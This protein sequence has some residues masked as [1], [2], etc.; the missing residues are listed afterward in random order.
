MR[1]QIY[2]FKS[3]KVKLI[4]P[5]QAQEIDYYNSQI[6]ETE[7]TL[8]IMS[9]DLEK[10]VDDPKWPYEIRA[11]ITK[12]KVKHSFQYEGNSFLVSMKFP[13]MFIESSLYLAQN[14]W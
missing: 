9:T 13:Y 7:K 6:E 11:F 10:I 5:M 2:L 4:D 12:Y 8:N 14:N 3:E 1:K